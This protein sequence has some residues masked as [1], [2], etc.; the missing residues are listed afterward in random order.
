MGAA[1]FLAAGQIATPLAGFSC[2]VAAED[3]ATLVAVFFAVDDATR[4]LDFLLEPFATAPLTDAAFL[5]T[6]LTDNALTEDAFTDDAFMIG[7]TCLALFARDFEVRGVALT[8]A[9]AVIGAV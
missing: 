5:G 7:C 9:L 6:P 2:F 8:L 4:L 3:V 1:G